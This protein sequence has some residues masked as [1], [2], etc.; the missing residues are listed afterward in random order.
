MLVTTD[1]PADLDKYV[2]DIDRL[3]M[4]IAQD[5]VFKYQDQQLLLDILRREK[6]R[7]T[8]MKIEKEVT[9]SVG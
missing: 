3:S 1:M 6:T 9:R 8:A 2:Q 5:Y 4:F 7:A